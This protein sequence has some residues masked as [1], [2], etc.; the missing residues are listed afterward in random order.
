MT[1][2]YRR[3]MTIVETLQL[4]TNAAEQTE[5]LCSYAWLI[6]SDVSLKFTLIRSPERIGLD[7]LRRAGHRR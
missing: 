4:V 1:S 5:H 7:V 2:L 6:L 3:T